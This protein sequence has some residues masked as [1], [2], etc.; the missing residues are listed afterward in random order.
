VELSTIKEK[1]AKRD[2]PLSEVSNKGI[3]SIKFGKFRS[4]YSLPNLNGEKKEE[5]NFGRLE[6]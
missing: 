4:I 2:D 6:N 1:K 5:K 3:L